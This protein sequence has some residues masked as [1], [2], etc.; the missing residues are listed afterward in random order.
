MKHGKFLF[1]LALLF[2]FCQTAF[3][4]DTESK[5][6]IKTKN[7]TSVVSGVVA[8]EQIRA[9]AAAKI[10][11]RLGTSDSSRIVIQKG[12]NSFGAGW[13]REFDKLLAKAS[14]AKS[15]ILIFSFNPDDGYPKLSKKI[16][17]AE[18][19]LVDGQ[20]F[21]LSD[22]PG[23]LIVLFFFTSWSEPGLLQVKELNDFYPKIAGR[24]VKLIGISAESGPEEE[25]FLRSFS[26]KYGSRFKFGL[27]DEQT[28]LN[29]R[30]IS[31]LNAVP[32]TFII[33]NG[34]LRGIFTGGG[35]KV[36]NKLK[37][38]I[39]RNLDENKL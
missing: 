7:G 28:F 2:L 21:S 34:K 32:Q 39:V 11:D 9:E 31:S 35:D 37:E 17:E 19:A 6:I 18:F 20:K 4:Q 3:P 27:T 12:V 13:Q 8:N 30:E 1:S 14:R 15:G 24:Q 23:K 25:K 5:I 26:K 10:K 22:E 36:I 29:F 38:E 33:F 16:A